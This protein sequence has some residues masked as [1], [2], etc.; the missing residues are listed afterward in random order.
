MNFYTRWE[1]ER[2]ACL[3]QLREARLGAESALNEALLTADLV[4]RYEPYATGDK[5]RIAIRARALLRRIGEGS[6]RLAD[7]QPLLG[8]TATDGPAATAPPLTRVRLEG[9]RVLATKGEDGEIRL[10]RGAR[11]AVDGTRLVV[12]FAPGQWTGEIKR[13]AFSWTAP[14]VREHPCSSTIEDSRDQCATQ[15]QV[16]SSTL[17]VSGG[18]A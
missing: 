9:G 3:R 11:A 6:W 15:L 13:A 4:Y 14:T 18:G 5:R 17:M 8:L 12:R 7:P 2:A 1:R 16:T 10:L